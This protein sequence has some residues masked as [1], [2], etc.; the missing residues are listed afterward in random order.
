MA[1]P[2]VENTLT[3]DV[4]SGTACS[5]TVPGSVGASDVCIAAILCDGDE[6]F[7]WDTGWDEIDV[8]SGEGCSVGMARYTGDP[9]GS[10]DFTISSNERWC[11]GILRISG[12]DTAD[13]V[14][15][16]ASGA[17]ASRTALQIRPVTTVN[18]D[19]LIISAGVHDQ[20]DTGGAAGDTG[21]W[22]LQDFQ[23]SGGGNNGVDAIVST[24]SMVSAGSVPNADPFLYGVFDDGDGIAE[25]TV[26]LNPG[27]P[28]VVETDLLTYERGIY[29]RMSPIR[30]MG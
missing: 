2:V 13:I 20:E 17:S 25:V 6:T 24:R 10:A 30:G 18:D 14:E 23:Q 8:A 27:T 28:P 5:P 1:V 15:D 9:T 21:V 12:V 16:F 4:G 3:M 11:A 22:T 19:C 26:A 29:R 7:T